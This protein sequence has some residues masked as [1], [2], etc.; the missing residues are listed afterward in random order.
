MVARRG[1]PGRCLGLDRGPRP[2]WPRAP[3]ALLR[4]PRGPPDEVFTDQ[5]ICLDEDSQGRYAFDPDHNGY[6]H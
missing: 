6:S 3:I 4:P 2:P 1:P 5:T